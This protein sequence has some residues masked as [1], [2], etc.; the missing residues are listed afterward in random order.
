MSFTNDPYEQRE[1]WGFLTV[2]H[3]GKTNEI[4]ITSDLPDAVLGKDVSEALDRSGFLNNLAAKKV[5]RIYSVHTHPDLSRIGRTASV[6]Y[7]VPNAT[8]ALTHWKLKQ[9]IYRINPDVVIPPQ[10]FMGVLP[11]YDGFQDIMVAAPI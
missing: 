4:F 10:L 9:E 7:L 6:E 3:H 8:D 5:V 11:G 1:V 2:D